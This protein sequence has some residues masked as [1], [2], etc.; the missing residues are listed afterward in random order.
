MK[1][2]ADDR[3]Y[4]L[5]QRRLTVS[6]MEITI[7]KIEKTQE[8]EK[9]RTCS[10]GDIPHHTKGTGKLDKAIHTEKRMRAGYGGGGGRH[11]SVERTRDEIRA[12][13][14]SV[15]RRIRIRPTLHRNRLVLSQLGEKGFNHLRNIK[16][17]REKRHHRPLMILARGAP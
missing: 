2:L 4:A 17:E 3:Y 13:A 1:N 6:L 14:G 11:L 15:F 12:P 7:L 10:T 8:V 16:I 9:K 5:V